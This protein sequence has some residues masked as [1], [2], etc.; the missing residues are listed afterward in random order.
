MAKKEQNIAGLQQLKQQLRD[1]KPGR[2]YFFYGEETFL[3][4][5]YLEQL[6]KFL[7][8]PLT[9]SFNYHK[10]NNETFSVEDFA[11]CVENLPM[12]AETTMVVVDEIDLF[13]ISEPDRNRVIEVVSDIPDYCT[14]VFTYVSE[15]WSLKTVWGVGYK[16]E[17][18]KI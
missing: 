14:I 11:D 4:H 12:M 1:K 5:H 3:L 9:E 18:A 6:R 16:F 8:D 13:S 10:L 2:L 15:E 7:V 17:I